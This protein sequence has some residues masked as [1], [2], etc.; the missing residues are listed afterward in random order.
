MY[1]PL[2]MNVLMNDNFLRPPYIIKNDSSLY[3]NC[4]MAHIQID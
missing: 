2:L 3:N 1:V 4:R